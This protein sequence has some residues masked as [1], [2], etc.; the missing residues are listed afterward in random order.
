MGNKSTV[1]APAVDTF[2]PEGDKELEVYRLNEGVE[3]LNGP[4]VVGGRAGADCFRYGGQLQAGKDRDAG[5]QI[6]VPGEPAKAEW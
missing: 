5:I 2:T 3:P 6:Y 1:K 4:Y